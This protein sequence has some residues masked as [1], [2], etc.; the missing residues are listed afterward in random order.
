MTKV[1][2]GYPK[3][4]ISDANTIPEM[5]RAPPKGQRSTYLEASQH[6]LIILSIQVHLLGKI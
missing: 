1:G 2:S 3:L 4:R 6:Q 5:E